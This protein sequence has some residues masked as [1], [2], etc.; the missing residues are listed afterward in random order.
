MYLD[1]FL[2]L[3]NEAVAAKKAGQQ[4]ETMTMAD[5]ELV[6]TATV[7]FPAEAPFYATSKEETIVSATMA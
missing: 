5:A 1:D 6:T 7:G 3:T 4:Q 2:G